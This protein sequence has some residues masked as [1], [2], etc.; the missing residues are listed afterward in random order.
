MKKLK[1]IYTIIATTVM[2]IGLPTTYIYAGSSLDKEIAK[3]KSAPPK[4][5]VRLM[6]EL[7]RRIFSLNREQRIRAIRK[8]RKS[9]SASPNAKR[10]TKSE[11]STDRVHKTVTEHSQNIDSIRDRV[12][13]SNH[14][15]VTAVAHEMGNPTHHTD[16]MKSMIEQNIVK[17]VESHTDMDL[18]HTTVPVENHEE[19]P[20]SETPVADTASKILSE[21][22]KIPSD[23]TVSHIEESVKDKI[24]NGAH[25]VDTGMKTVSHPVD[26][27]VPV[28]KKP[29]PDTSKM[30]EGGSVNNAPEG[31]EP[32]PVSPKASVSVQV[33]YSTVTEPLKTPVSAPKTDI[34]I[35]HNSAPVHTDRGS[36]SIRGRGRR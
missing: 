26:V 36:F 33:Q 14:H 3:I 7:K 27:E 21:A 16:K 8:L 24:N 17:P 4:E 10:V 6:N 11:E 12:E 32:Q 28:D 31:V 5:R 22:S 15:A 25:S 2:L 18:P 29:T 30:I 20:V 19:I 1:S 34:K 23:T 35:E 13:M 9:I